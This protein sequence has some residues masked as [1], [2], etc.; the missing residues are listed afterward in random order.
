MPVQLFKVSVKN[1]HRGS[2]V[3]KLPDRKSAG[4]KLS[5]DWFMKSFVPPFCNH[6]ISFP[7]PLHTSSQSVCKFL[8]Y[9]VF[10]FSDEFCW[11]GIG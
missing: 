7:W 3:V 5:F 2:S 8:T 4:D 11:L 6:L 9:P 1:K 10:N